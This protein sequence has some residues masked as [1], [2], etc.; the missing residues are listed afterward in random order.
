VS[1]CLQSTSSIN[2]AVPVSL[3]SNWIGLALRNGNAGDIG[4][5]DR[6]WGLEVE[7][8]VSKAFSLKS[9]VAAIVSVVL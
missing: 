2:P 8:F 4:V 3:H 1:S 5:E 9:I 7:G 6:F